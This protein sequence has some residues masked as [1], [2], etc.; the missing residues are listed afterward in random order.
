MN[1]TPGD[2]PPAPRTPWDRG[3]QAILIVL[4]LA[5]IG[6]LLYALV[7]LRDL[8]RL[9]SLRSGQYLPILLVIVFAV[10]WYAVRVIATIRRFRRRS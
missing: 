5:L 7:S 2:G 1:A 9:R 6:A 8:A 10:I 3:L 4:L